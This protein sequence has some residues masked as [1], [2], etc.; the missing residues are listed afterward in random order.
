MAITLFSEPF[1]GQFYDLNPAYTRMP[2]NMIST[3]SSRV[4]MN[5]IADIYYGAYPFSA[6][7]YVGRIKSAPDLTYT[8]GQFDVHRIL[9]N[10]VSPDID[11]STKGIVKSTNSIKRWY[12]SFGE[13]FS[14][15]NAFTNATLRGSGVYSNRVKLTFAQPHNLLVGDA[16]Y[17][18]VDNTSATQPVP[19]NSYGFVVEIV[20]LTEVTMNWIYGAGGATTGY[21]TEG[22]SYT[23]VTNNNGYASFSASTTTR[24]KAG[25]QFIS[26]DLSNSFYNGTWSVRA[27][28]GT[29]QIITSI[30]YSGAGGGLGAIIHVGNVIT[31][32]V[33]DSTAYMLNAVNQY[34]QVNSLGLT[35]SYA[36][37]MLIDSTSDFLTQAPTG[38]TIQSGQ[39][40]SLAFLSHN[41]FGAT[42]P[43]TQIRVDLYFKDQTVNQFDIFMGANYQ[44]TAVSDYLR[45]SVGIGPKNINDAI[46]A[47]TISFS[48]INWANVD[49]YEVKAFASASTN[50]SIIRRFTLEEPD[51]K[52]ETYR[53]C[54][55][56]KLGGW[57]FFNFNKRSDVEITVN[58]D[59][60]STRP[61]SGNYFGHLVGARGENI[62]NIDG[63]ERHT[64]NS[65]WVTEE[66]SLWLSNLVS[67][68]SAYRIK[69]NKL[70]PIIIETNSVKPGK[71]ANQALFN[72]T[73]QFRMAYGVESQRG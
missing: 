69:D 54:W 38:Q 8:R 57:D 22:E 29:N 9:E 24:F 63:V 21:V 41:D 33:T 17:A 10:Y 13:E 30:P 34:D 28:S 52:Y 5:Y 39:S 35:R 3:F 62:Y 67:A 53:L 19:N 1:S 2:F 16:V 65:D 73:I 12:V 32:G 59:T 47:G 66:E 58:K 25:D 49:Y 26:M 42:T 15:V 23:V 45:F 43:T 60:Y 31:T 4:N 18:K 70:Y 61:V 64:I 56:N 44:P 27:I 6:A 72:M 51:C 7:T 48:T 46:T 14:S 55:L 36:P 11:W 50:T 20:S 68:Q 37:W 40:H 71:R